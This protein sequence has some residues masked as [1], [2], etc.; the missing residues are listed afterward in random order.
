MFLDSGS[1]PDGVTK[2][3][4]CIVGGGAAGITL[5]VELASSALQV[6]VLEGGGA[7]PEPDG[8]PIY[9]VLPGE[10]LQ[11]G[12]EA[13]R[14]FYF[15]GNTNYWFGNCRP[16]DEA[17]FEQRDWL[18]HSGWP[19]DLEELTPYYERAQRLSGL[20]DFRWY[21]VETCRPRLQDGP[22]NV[23]H[24]VLETRIVQTTPVFSFAELHRHH[25]AAAD[26]VR[27]WLGAHA[28]RL[29]ANSAGDR[30]TAVETIGPDGRL[31][32]VDAVTFILASGGVENA[33][34][35]LC[36]NETAPTGLGNDHDLVGRFFMEHLYFAFAPGQSGIADSKY[37]NDLRLY[38]V[39]V[40]DRISEL[41]TRQTVAD[42]KIWAQLVLSDRL[43]RKEQVAALG[44]WFRPVTSI[45]ESLKALKR[46]LSSLR[47]RVLPEHPVAD[48][49]AALSD[50][51]GAIRFLL[52]KLTGR[53]A[54]SKAYELL[55]QLEQK[56]DPENR[57][58]LST[59]LDRFGQ[60]QAELSLRMDDEQLRAHARSLKLAADE[61]GFKGDDLASELERKYAAGEFDFFRHHM[62]TTRMNDDPTKG[63]VDRDCR[64]HG[65]PNLFVAGS[66]VFPTG[67]TAAPTLTA[68]ALAVRLADH[69]LD[70]ARA[71]TPDLQE[72]VA[73]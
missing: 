50:P 46:L 1:R 52:W 71:I 41:K 57:I 25:L 72:P 37:R 58:R 48:F 34:L 65:M 60:P 35:L 31:S 21:G 40:G 17:D 68:V 19:I 30:V 53:G 14:P 33:R 12:S 6:V 38:D 47:S 56:P 42:A 23:S 70:G 28:L 49:R 69:I 39:G 2:A 44:L 26:N 51:V 5:A 64:V 3:D 63:V 16:F 4:V 8:R 66:S 20:G 36:S 67:G 29:K 10:S 27:I 73:R 15:G 32:T 11:L 43:M 22:V 13:S 59:C 62:G 18:P 54:P 61:L 9:R 55:V 7:T 24:S 45:P